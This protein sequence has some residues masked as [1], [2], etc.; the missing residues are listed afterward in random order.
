MT[1]DSEIVSLYFSTINVGA[2]LVLLKNSLKVQRF[3]K[4][5]ISFNIIS[6]KFLFFRSGARAKFIFI[7][8]WIS[9]YKTLPFESVPD[10]NEIQD[11]VLYRTL[12]FFRSV[13]QCFKERGK[14]KL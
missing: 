9:F 4:C 14:V 8:N 2:L 13:K 3:Q 6:I 10:S 5:D 7:Q 11:T 12:I 1:G